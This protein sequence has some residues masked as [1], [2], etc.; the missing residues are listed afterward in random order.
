MIK[1][2]INRYMW[3]KDIFEKIMA[4]VNGGQVCGERQRIIYECCY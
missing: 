2:D 1:N 3:K 4:E